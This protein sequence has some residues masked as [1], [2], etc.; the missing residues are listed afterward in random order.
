MITDPDR[1]KQDKS[2][3]ERPNFPYRCG[4]I[5][6]WSKPCGRGPSSEGACGGVAECRPFMEN[7][8]WACRRSSRSGGVCDEG[9]RPDGTCSHPHPPCK[10]MLSLRGYRGRLTFLAAALVVAMISALAFYGSGASAISSVN[11]GGLSGGHKN[12]T[13]KQGCATCHK[14]HGSGAVEWLQAS[15]SPGSL[16]QS[17]ESCHA[18][19]GPATTPHNEQFKTTGAK[20][21]TECTMCHTEHKG[22]DA[23]IT[24]LS[25]TQCSACHEKRFTSFSEGHP[26]FS[27]DYPSRRRTAIAFD[28]TSHLSKH[29][30]DKRFTDR[31]PK[32]LCI[33]CHNVTKAARNVPVRPFQESCAKCHESQI[34]KRELVLFSLP[35]FEENPFDAAAVGEACGPT[36]EA[37]EAAGDQLA[38]ITE[39]L[40]EL[41]EGGANPTAAATLGK[42]L[43]TL[44][45]RLGFGEPI[46]PAEEYE[47]VSTETLPPTAVFLLGI[48]DGEDAEAYS[49]PVRDMIMGTIENGHE[50]LKA[51]LKGRG[52]PNVLLNDLSPELLRGIGCAWASNV[53]YEAPAGEV[54]GGWFADGL[55]LRYRPNRHADPVAKAWLNLAAAGGEGVT[56]DLRDMLL[57][58]SEGPGA[59]TKCH[60]VS[61]DSTA[62]DKLQVEWALGG[63]S[64]QRHLNYSHGPHLNLL[65]PGATC[66]TCHKLNETAD[67]FA[68]FKHRNPLDFESNF[69][70]IE[71][72]TCTACHAKGQVR[73]E[74]TLC[75]EYHNGNQFKRR[76]TS[77]RAKDSE[78]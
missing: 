71:N 78:S 55:S 31:T 35:E 23:K 1:F 69:K 56:D 67:Y 14:P 13:A 44:K 48:E 52:D 45:G 33:G 65:G 72:N 25:D 61:E 42:E 70:S 58:R 38:E 21:T 76:M 37:R 30:Q 2:P 28:H 26:S 34:A 77:S 9:P 7:G 53:E 15:W 27:K 60:S 40:A 5:G 20:R 29:F 6:L 57:S 74:C 12:F 50:P 3:Y 32:E 11:P 41:A 49:E 47:S 39:K 63:Q 22:M 24:Q 10:P 68:A 8:R 4:R 19:S 59:C 18:F 36:L 54:S 66:Q 16:S 62:K 17:C 73:Q 43:E 51:A 64:R 46:E 75:H